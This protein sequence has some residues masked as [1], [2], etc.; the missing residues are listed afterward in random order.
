MKVWIAFLLLSCSS[1]CVVAE[2]VPR[3][4]RTISGRVTGVS[5]PPPF[6]SGLIK[7]WLSVHIRSDGDS[8]ELELLLVYLS[9][10]Q[11]TPR[12]GDHCV[13]GVH[14]EKEGGYV[15][16]EIVPMHDAWILDD[17]H[18]DSVETSSP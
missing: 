4:F 2:G 3:D 10:T 7:T 16:R 14:V 6:G 15:G 5:S 13:F 12:V 8:A 11:P 18:C 1:T 9:G 17:F